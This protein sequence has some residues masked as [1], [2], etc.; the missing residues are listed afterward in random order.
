MEVS[1]LACPYSDPDPKIKEA[2][3]SIA[4]K[5]TYE[6]LRQGRFVY[7]PLT[8]NVPV[9]RLGIHG[10]WMTWK[11][12]DH[13]MLKKC[14]RLIVLKL[15]GW[16][17][18]RGVAAEIDCARK[19]GLPIE[20]MEIDEEKYF[21]SLAN[22]DS[23]HK[24]L[25][26]RMLTFYAERDWSQYHS[27]KN[28][29]MNLAVEVGE[30]MESF[31]WLTEAQ[32]FVESPEELNKIKDE[33]GDVFTVLLHLSHT[34]GIDLIEASKEKLCKTAKKYPVEKCKGL[35]HKYTKYEMAD[36]KR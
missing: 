22:P 23:S 11:D 15:H 33:I 34:L 1:Y 9:D 31:R 3:A 27:P 14:G 25:L 16:E 35:A 32:S 29:V 30:L 13:T 21:R 28:L 6:L 19:N 12:F 36:D 10:D 5:V 20:W 8:H 7:S 24:E 26:E 18:S 2:R 17:N 4:T